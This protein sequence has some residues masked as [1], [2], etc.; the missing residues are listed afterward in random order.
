MS[1]HVEISGSYFYNANDHGGN[2]YGYGVVMGNSNTNCLIENNIFERLRHSMGIG[3]GSNCNVFTYNFS[4]DQYSIDYGVFHQAADLCLHG[5]YSFANLYEENLIEWIEAD[6]K[7]GEH[8][9]FNVFVRNKTYDYTESEWRNI[10]LQD[11]PHTS[12]LG[13][14]LWDEND[15]AI[16]IEGT[17][18][19]L[20]FNGY[21]I[22]N[23]VMRDHE[24]FRGNPGARAEATNGD[25]SY[26]YSSTP[27]FMQGMPFPS[28]G[29][30]ATGYPTP[31]QDIP[32]RARFSSGPLTYL[33]DPFPLPGDNGYT[34][35]NSEA[36][37]TKVYDNEQWT[38]LAP[39]LPGL[40]AGVYYCD[41]WMIEGTISL[42]TDY[43]YFVGWPST[44]G[45]SFDSYN[46]ARLYHISLLSGDGS[47][48]TVRTCFYR[49]NEDLQG[50][51]VNKWAPWDPTKTAAQIHLYCKRGETTSGTLTE[52]EC[53]CNT[54][55]LTGDVTVPSG[56]NLTILPGTTVRVPAGKKII[57][58]GALIAQGTPADS[59]IFDKSGS[60][61]WYG[62]VFEDPSTD[63]NCILEYCTIWNCSYAVYCNS[64][65]PIIKNSTIGSTYAG[66]STFYSNATIQDNSVHLCNYGL[67]CINSSPQIIG[68]ILL[69]NQQSPQNGRGI[70]LSMCGDETWIQGNTIDGWKS[71]G[72]AIYASNPSILANAVY[73]NMDDGIDCQGY[74]N[75]FFAENDIYS[76][77]LS[78]IRVS[79]TSM[80]DLLNG[81]NFIAGNSSYQ[82][83]SAQSI[84]ID[85]R[86][87]CWEPIPPNLYG[88]I[89]WQPYS[90]GCF[91]SM[92]MGTTPKSVGNVS[93]GQSDSTTD[94]QI[95]FSTG[96]KH[97]LVKEYA[98]AASEYELVISEYPSAPEAPMALVRLPRC[99]Q[100]L[101]RS[102]DIVPYFR[103]VSGAHPNLVVGGMALLL[104]AGHL[105]KNKAYDL[106]LN[107]HNKIIETFKD[108]DLSKVARFATWEILF[109]GR[110]DEIGAKEVLKEYAGLYPDDENTVMMKMAM[111][112]ITLED[113]QG[114]GKLTQPAR[115]SEKDKSMASG[116]PKS[117][118]LAG[119]YPNPFNPETAIRYEIPE[120]GRV[121]IKIFNIQ[122]K[123]VVTLYDGERSAGKYVIPWN[124][125]DRHGQAVASGVYFYQVRLINENVSQM[126]N[127]KMLLLR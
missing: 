124:G 40:A 41:V 81:N 56:V 68:N 6:G 121:I 98:E 97:E 103:I 51:Q 30:R 125:T 17:S 109:N 66:V 116:L 102:E 117:F 16:E 75:P 93:S 14:E 3:T 69:G 110:K 63:N 52:N 94:A 61:T 67:W 25:V 44:I 107:N 18:A 95:H 37:L 59:I 96:Y 27:D 9:P 4:T 127:D 46:D 85:A 113:L 2:S 114:L 74:A 15:E 7:H 126:L 71:E 119:N 86:Y 10:K 88:N 53:W 36:T 84:Q 105:V 79:N 58:N 104:E 78:G 24:Y 38:F 35:L 33:P 28:I 115:E 73:L 8:G 60:S 112:E 48:M 80:P 55:T 90:T 100:K 111:G 72:I 45:Y 54:K 101:R 76:N 42:P 123:E 82:M 20:A 1:S 31:S 64:A 11:A 83:Y 87:N 21:G 118:A 23:S 99:Y 39:P 89:L 43:C 34:V 108:S 65:S 5:R 47:A 50:Q 29:P 122:G 92:A 22:H 70:N 57:V 32:A 77:G 19:P 91:G 62:I 49:I 12:V 26:Y 13:C 106:A 120:D